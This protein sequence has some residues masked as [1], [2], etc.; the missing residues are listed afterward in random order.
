MSTGFSV[1]KVVLYLKGKYTLVY[2]IINNVSI[3]SS[4]VV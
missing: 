4:V 2:Q 1:I 3:I